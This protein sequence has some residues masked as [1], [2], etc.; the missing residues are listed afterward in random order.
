MIARRIA[1][2]SATSV[3][4]AAWMAIASPAAPANDSEKDKRIQSVREGQ[5][6]DK[7]QAVHSAPNR[8]DHD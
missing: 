7:P 6:R 8:K 2:T 3:I 4:H 1:L 5:A